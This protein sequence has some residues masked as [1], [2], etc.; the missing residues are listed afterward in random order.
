MSRLQ[1]MRDEDA[2]VIARSIADDIV[3]LRDQ[4]DSALE[5]YMLAEDCPERAG[6]IAANRLARAALD[7]LPA[8]IAQHGPFCDPADYE[9]AVKI[10]TARVLQ[11][12]DGTGMPTSGSA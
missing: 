11:I 5:L 8:A 7:E 10:E 12:L 4:L 3:F 9:R 2:A 6:L 1:Q